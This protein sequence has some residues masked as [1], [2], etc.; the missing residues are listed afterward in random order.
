MGRIFTLALALVVS[1]TLGLGTVAHATEPLVSLDNRVAAELGHTPTDGDEVPA[2][3]DKA[4]PHHH[5]DCHGHQFAKADTDVDQ[6][7]LFLVAS[8]PVMTVTTLTVSAR[9]SPGLRPPIA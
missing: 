4:F 9:G 1:L 8:S 7:G 5:A 3:H 2:D 6:P